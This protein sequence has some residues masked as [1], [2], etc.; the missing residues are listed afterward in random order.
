[1]DIMLLH[2]STIWHSY[3]HDGVPCVY[4]MINTY[5]RAFK[6]LTTLF[7][8]FL[9]SSSVWNLLTVPQACFALSCLCS[10]AFLCLEVLSLPHCFPATSTK[11]VVPWRESLWASTH[12]HLIW[13]WSHILVSLCCLRCILSKRISGLPSWLFSDD[14]SCLFSWSV[15]FWGF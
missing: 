10:G 15:R 5:N 4:W 13:S 8:V 14:S 2:M 1:M 9:I 7:S 12:F 11:Q 3:L 6:N